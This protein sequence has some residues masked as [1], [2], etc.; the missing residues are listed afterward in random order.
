MEHR[1]IQVCDLVFTDISAKL[2]VATIKFI[3][4]I[5]KLT[6]ILEPLIQQKHQRQ[7]R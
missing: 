6:S 7:W 3:H 5:E 1:Q 2:D 4:R